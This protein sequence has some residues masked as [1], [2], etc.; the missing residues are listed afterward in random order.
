MKE[1]E[2]FFAMERFRRLSD[3]ETTTD[4]GLG[5]Q[6][7]DLTK[8]LM[9]NQSI[10]KNA[11]PNQSNTI[12]QL[13]TKIDEAACHTEE[14]VKNHGLRNNSS[15]IRC[16][17]L[18]SCI[19]KSHDPHASIKFELKEL[20]YQ[21]KH[22]L[23]KLSY[24]VSDLPAELRE[25]DE[26]ERLDYYSRPDRNSIGLKEDKVQLIEYL[27]DESED[28]KVI[29]LCGAGGVGKTTL[30][31]EIYDHP[32]IWYKFLHR[33]W[34]PVSSTFNPGNILVQIARYFDRKNCTNK[35]EDELVDI[36]IR[37]IREGG[38]FLFVLDDIWSTEVLDELQRI[39]FDDRFSPITNKG[40]RI[41]VTTRKRQVAEYVNFLKP[42][43][44]Y[45]VRGLKENDAWE[46]L[47]EEYRR[48]NRD[49]K[50]SA[51][52]ENIGKEMVKR[53]EGIPVAI[54]KLGQE[55]AGKESL[56]EWNIVHQNLMSFLTDN[57]LQ[58]LA[59]SF[60]DLPDHLKLCFI[61]LGL[62]PEDSVIDA[63]KLYHFWIV[64]GLV[65]PQDIN[66]AEN[67]LTELERM[68]MVE[69]EEEEVPSVRRLKCCRISR[70]MR[71]LCISKG[72]QINFSHINDSQLG[73][74]FSSSSSRNKTRRLIV[75][76]E[77][78]EDSG[79]LAKK[80]RTRNL[81]SLHILDAHKQQGR[82]PVR[83]SG[84]FDVEE[85]RLLRLLD[86][87]GVDIGWDEFTVDGMSNIRQN[88]LLDGISKLVH[89]R[90]LSFKRCILNQLPLAISNLLYLQV[91]DLRVDDSI[92]EVILP[93][94]LWK[95][96]KMKHLYLPRMFQTYTGDKL[97]LDGLTELETLENFITRVC[98][99]TDLQTLTELHNLAVKIDGDLTDLQFINE[100]L[101]QPS[102][103]Q[104]QL[105][106]D[107][108]NF[109]CYEDNRHSA[110]RELLQYQAVQI[111]HIEGHIR[112]L[113]SKNKISTSLT[114][115]V[116]IGS[117]LEKDPMEK[118]SKLP[119]LCV[120]VLDDNAFEGTHM[121]SPP[122]GF[123]ELKRL[124]IL[125]L[126]FLESWTVKNNP[127]P[128]LCNIRI[129]NCKK[130]RILHDFKLLAALKKVEITKMPKP[131]ADMLHEITSATIEDITRSQDEAEASSGLQIA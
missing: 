111:I 32:D 33:I 74:D 95:L 120:L 100:H 129:E 61:Y 8:L 6:I 117:E 38:R 12:E 88:G 24:L 105:S 86:F 20:Y 27:M 107:V 119:N 122:S 72:N 79:I 51:E 97:R 68:S 75:C 26:W 66:V 125:N 15:K 59:P 18:P 99:V 116:L 29:S 113:P 22:A 47:M 71:Q 76:L 55:L 36:I 92:T 106:I 109:D 64:E 81:H 43:S 102:N 44:V 54:I 23:Q 11:G 10:L 13:I 17:N 25:K 126:M 77:K 69:V 56:D 14:A 130:L 101:K 49:D 4:I 114:K 37:K 110:I 84:K 78:L 31:Y 40:H 30:A 91:L 65:K 46:L 103:K 90:Y 89:L 9:D 39:L 52:K 112:E 127:M 123:A 70:I 58:V 21:V 83:L 2:I 42:P 121:V 108:R 28:L 62:W 98:N 48:H 67:Y 118:L 35:S 1:L 93:N 63:D 50:L 128:K 85:L 5:E 124:E 57:V 41:L 82:T 3:E 16:L 96:R 94:V 115:L 34:I 53:C 45:T 19:S 7:Q 131:F 80:E 87:D 104:I 60:D 73:S